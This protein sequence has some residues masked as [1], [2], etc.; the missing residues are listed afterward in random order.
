MAEVHADSEITYTDA[1]IEDAAASFV[2]H[3]FNTTYG[4]VLLLACVINI[5]AF[6]LVFSLGIREWFV[7]FVVGTLAAMGPIYLAIFQA[8]RE[9]PE[10]FVLV[11]SRLAFTVIP[12]KDLP[13]AW[14]QVIREASTS[15]AA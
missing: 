3:F 6:V 11:I 12:K 2:R 8:V 10:Y 13:V 14:L 9:F 7:L 1:V 4:R 5:A 15:R